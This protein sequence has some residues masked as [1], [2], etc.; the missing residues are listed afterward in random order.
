MAKRKLQDQQA[1]DRIQK[2]ALDSNMVVMA[3]AGAGKTHALVERMVNYVRTVSPE[4]DRIAAITFTR[5]AAGEMR[6]RFLL[7]L[8]EQLGK[9][10]GQEAERLQLALDRVD[11]CFIGTIHSFCGQLLRERPVE[12][13]IRPDFKEL[14]QRDETRLSRKAWDDFVQSCFKPDDPLKA[15]DPRI[16]EL[17]ALGVGLA[18][19]HSFFNERC[20]FSDLP[21]RKDVVDRPDIE[22]GVELA[23]AFMEE[24]KDYIPDVLEKGPDSFMQAFDRAQLF[25]AHCDFSTDRQQITLLKLVHEASIKGVTLNRWGDHR[26]F[27]KRLKDE[28]APEFADRLNPVLVQW[29]QRVYGHVVDF[30]DDAVEFYDRERQRGGHMTFQDL[31]R[32]STQLLRDYPEVRGYFQARFQSLFV[33]E[34]QDTDPIQAEMLFYL[35]GKNLKGKEWQQ[36]KPASGS[37]FLVG[38]EKQSIY[39]FRRADVDIFRLVS[40]RLQATGGSVEQLNTSFRSLG[41]LCDWINGAFEPLFAGYDAQYQAEYAPLLPFRPNG[42]DD[43]CVRKITIGHIGHHRR[44]EI[45]P[46]EAERIVGFIAA[47]LQGQTTFNQEGDDALLGERAEPGDFMILTQTRKMLPFFASALEACGIPYDVSGGGQLSDLAEVR[48]FVGMLEAVYQPDNALPLLGYLRGPLVGVGDD[49]LFVF[50]TEGGQF[51]YTHSEAVPESVPEAVRIRFQVA[52]DRLRACEKLLQ[53]QTPAMAIEQMMEE[54]VLPCFAAGGEM[55]SSRAGSLLRILALVRKWESQGWHWGQITVELRELVTDDE[56]KV[57]EMTL[58]SGQENVVKLM[59]IHQ[60]KGLQAKVV[61][62]ADAGDTRIA[63]ENVSFHVSRTGDKPYLALPVTRPLGEFHKELLAEP[64]GWEEDQAEELQFL[65]G[66]KMRLVYVAATRAE[67]LLVVSNYTGENKGGFSWSWLYPYLG[68]VPELPAYAVVEESG[69]QEEMPD[70]DRL[71]RVRAERWAKVKMPSYAFQ[72]V[73]EELSNKEPAEGKWGRGRDYGSLVHR[74]FEMAILGNLPDGEE[75]YIRQELIHVGL[76]EEVLADA[77]RAID[78]FKASEIWREV[79]AAEA[80]HTEVPFA[81][82]PEDSGVIRGIIDLVYRVDGGWKIVDYK[83][84]YKQGKISEVV[85]YYA[86]QVNTYAEKWQALSGEAV[87]EKGLWLVDKKQWC[88]VSM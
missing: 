1:R 84:G 47:A 35:T 4:I 73:A 62:L 8:Q 10:R 36:L 25:V 51:D 57:E 60:A 59:N 44:K 16:G 49:E 3:G 75:E 20:Q 33:D 67:N 9:A 24:V 7:R 11:Q 14:D 55:G 29:R 64:C 82:A 53:T 79:L 18:D 17:E 2:D 72:A 43:C 45:V 6:G 78:E 71:D 41:G 34:F 48:A 58:E 39:R 88:G 63:K 38:D 86:P 27:A 22:K 40:K 19:L 80:V 83:T 69:G 61:F 76:E 13:G 37:L 21:L 28:I 52:F 15:D 12:A 31:L 56:Y 87:V 23:R 46:I 5:K 68:N 85:A 30:I 50:K 74:L 42:Q 26:V 65:Q 66:E 54:L 32:R 70:F 81:V 77:Q